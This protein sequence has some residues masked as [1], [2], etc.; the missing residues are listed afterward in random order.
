MIQE[1]LDFADAEEMK[2]PAPFDRRSVHYFL[3]LDVEGNLIGISP[4]CGRTENGREQPGKEFDCPV[5]FPLKLNVK[6][7]VISNGGGGNPV[8]ELLTG[9][10]MEIFGCR[11]EDDGSSV[12]IQGTKDEDR[13]PQWVRLHNLVFRHLRRTGLLTGPHRAIWSFV[14]KPKPFEEC[15]AL[16]GLPDPDGEARKATTKDEEK[17]LRDKAEKSRK[18]ILRRIGGAKFAFRVGTAVMLK[19]SALRAAH[20]QYYDWQR[21][22]VIKR[23]EPG[24]D[25]YSANAALSQET[26][27]LTPVFPHISGVP[28][29]SGGPNNWCPLASFDKAPFKSYGLDSRTLSMRLETAERASAAL[30]YMLRHP[31]HHLKLDN[32][33]AIFWAVTDTGRVAP[34]DFIEF[35]NEPDALEVRQFL[36]NLWGHSAS[37]PDSGRFYC[38]LLS[39]PKARI[40]VRAWHTE[41]LPE[42]VANVDRHFETVAMPDLNEPGVRAS[43]LAE[44]AGATVSA[45][46]KA[47]PLQ[48]TLV[49]LFNSALFGRKQP[50]P[51]AVFGRAIERQAIELAKGHENTSG[52]RRSGNDRLRHRAALIRLHL[53]FNQGIPM[54]EQTILSEK[55]KDPAILCGRLLALL[56]KI[57]GEAHVQRDEKNKIT[58]KGTASSPAN[59]F[60][61]A[62]SKTPALVFPRLL[63]LARVHLAK[64]GKD[65]AYRLEFGW[66]PQDSEKL[67]QALDCPFAGLAGVIE[68]LSLTNRC[69]FPRL[70]SLEEQGKFALGFYYERCRVWPRYKKREDSGGNEP[71]EESNIENQETEETT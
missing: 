9:D 31:Y 13:R 19:D 12:P 28:V 41:F 46:A 8:P 40:T 38:G 45:D 32:V 42:I 71:G 63:D 23:L 51:P 14:C 61:G 20:R 6:A 37:A 59:R 68:Q 50:L 30:N 36:Q 65:K 54:N 29:V 21:R 16:F 4:A 15:L 18:A 1:L 33:V 43:T 24:W 67:E 58:S 60:Y 52:A 44:L 34:L 17:K 11:L 10:T 35:M 27:C 62:A 69:E 66:S 26:G 48:T 70:F 56:D 49:A 3:D 53:N 25:S 7:E 2:T 22:R 5:F 57:H 47:P 64:I 55:C 39:S